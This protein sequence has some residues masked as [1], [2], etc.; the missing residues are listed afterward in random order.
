MSRFGFGLL[1]SGLVSCLCFLAL[2]PCAAAPANTPGGALSDT[3]GAASKATCRIDVFDKHNVPFCQGTGF[4]LETG[5]VITCHHVMGVAGAARATATFSGGAPCE[6]EGIVGKDKPHDLVAVALKQAPTDVGGLKLGELEIP[7]VGREVITVG[8]PLG[9]ALTVSK[10]IITSLP[11]GAD[12]NKSAGGRHYPEDM[13]LIQ[14]DA[15]IS[16]GN[17]GGPLVDAEGRVLAVMASTRTGGQSLNFGIPSAYIRPMLAA[18]AAPA[19]FTALENSEEEAATHDLV[20]PPRQ[21]KVT[22]AQAQ[23]LIAKLGNMTRCS[24]CA[25]TGKVTHSKTETITGSGMS[26]QRE[27]GTE[28]SVCLKCRGVGHLMT[29][30]PQAY[31]FLAQLAATL[32]Y[33]HTDATTIRPADRKKVLDAAAKVIGGVSKSIP[34][35]YSEKAFDLLRNADDNKGV[36]VCFLAFVDDKVETINKD[37][38]L[39]TMPGMRDVIVVLVCPPDYP[40]HGGSSFCNAPQKLDRWL[41]WLN[42]G[43]RVQAWERRGS[44]RGSGMERISRR[45]WRWRRSRNSGP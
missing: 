34:V 2:P 24:A 5:E 21:D 4:L 25:G 42:R 30:K 10:G 31:E 7:Q 15:S 44:V 17:S 22:M 20:L 35:D 18:K 37:Y 40:A 14:T 36:G 29:D 39:A 28:T 13:R 1:M 3:I 27:A 19:K 32:V 41:S 45:G 12:V 33:M 43:G 16:S 23:A 6:V 11:T 38:Y 26:Y 9:L 8:Y